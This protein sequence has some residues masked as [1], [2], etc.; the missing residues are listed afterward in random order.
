[1]SVNPIVKQECYTRE[2]LSDILDEEFSHT[3]AAYD[4][5]IEQCTKLASV[6][7]YDRD[8][9]L[10]NVMPKTMQEKTDT[11][12]I[13]D[14]YNDGKEDCISNKL[15]VQRMKKRWRDRDELIASLNLNQEQLKLLGLNDDD[16]EEDSQP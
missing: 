11:T 6:M 3:I 12:R 13:A 5:L 4:S 16:D 14:W 1:M 10:K 7:G 15:E 2:E 8:Y 9:I